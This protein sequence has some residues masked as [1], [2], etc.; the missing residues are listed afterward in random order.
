MEDV[1]EEAILKTWPATPVE[2]V[3]R[4]RKIL[5]QVYAEVVP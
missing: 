5:H 1:N 4:I 2:S 3:A